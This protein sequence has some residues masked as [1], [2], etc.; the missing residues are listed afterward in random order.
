[1][2]A[3][4]AKAHAEAAMAEASAALRQ[5][6]Q[7]LAEL[8][9]SLTTARGRVDEWT[10]TAGAAAETAG[11]DA[12]AQAVRQLLAAE[13]ATLALWPQVQACEAQWQRA[14]QVAADS[15][16]QLQQATVEAAKWHDRAAPLPAAAPPAAAATE[17]GA[18][19]AVKH[20]KPLTHAEICPFCRLRAGK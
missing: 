1:L 12:R 14:K 4:E 6:E 18:P 3:R 17:P 19:G 10:K 15:Q 9:T 5:N 8:R 13:Q 7:R 20:V 11:D 2:L 16:V